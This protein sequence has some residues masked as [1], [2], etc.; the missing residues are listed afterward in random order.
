[1]SRAVSLVLALTASGVLSLAPFMLA[2]NVTGA[3]HGVLLFLMLGIS[4]AFIHG[5]GFVPRARIIR[6]IASPAVA[7]PLIG[8]ATSVLLLNR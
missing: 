3:A 4:A 6:V 1:M 8:L 7:W 2:R 5:V